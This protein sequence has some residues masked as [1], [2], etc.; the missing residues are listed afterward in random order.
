M[1]GEKFL[2]NNA[3]VITEKAATQTSEGIGDANKI[4]ALDS[5]GKFDSSL[6]PVGVSVETDQIVCTEDLIA[7]NFINIYSSSGVKCRKA[8][9]TTIG[10]EANGFVLAGFTNGQTATIYR[11]SQSNTQLTGMTPGVK[12]YLS[13][14][15][16][17]RTE[18]IPSASGNVV[19]LLGISKSSSELI[20]V[21]SQ[22][23]VLA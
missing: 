15:A 16:G 13:T 21:L 9:A 23:I 10:K 22:P 14:T 6:M 18:T 2:Y 17:L 19:Q 8:D 5:T 12:Q 3:G 4:T 11:I 7:G 1:A 20:F